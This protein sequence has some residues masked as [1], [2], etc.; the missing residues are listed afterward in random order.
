MNTANPILNIAQTGQLQST[1]I[2]RPKRSKHA[3]PAV[4]SPRYLIVH[5]VKCQ[6]V[7]T[8]TNHKTES[9]FFDTPRL[10]A[11]DSKASSLRGTKPAAAIT[12]DYLED[13]PEI[14]FIVYKSYNCNK[15]YEEVKDDFDRLPTPSVDPAVLSLF[16]AYFFILRADGKDAVPYSES[17]TITSQDLTRAI[18]EA[19]S[20]SHGNITGLD[21]LQQVVHPYEQFYHSR[22]VISQV[23]SAPLSQ[24]SSKSRQ[25]LHL[26]YKF[27]IDSC[28]ANWRA[29]D[30]LFQSGM[31]NE[32]H[33]PKLFG[34][35][36]VLVTMVDAHPMAYF[37]EES[38]TAGESGSLQFA[39]TS[40]TFDQVFKQRTLSITVQWPR[41]Q[42]CIPITA[43]K[44]YPLRYDTSGLEERLRKR[45]EQ[46]WACRQKAFV[47]YESPNPT[48]DLQT[49]SHRSTF[50]EASI[51]KTETRQKTPRYMVDDT[52][53]KQMH[54][55]DSVVAPPGNALG[56]LEMR[57]EQPPAGP[58]L[59]LLPAQIRGYG[60]HDKKWSEFVPRG[61][62]GIFT[63]PF[64]EPWVQNLTAVKVSAL[65][66]A[67]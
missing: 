34:S 51:N 1:D 67:P 20:L 16:K 14:S 10:F 32:I 17:F 19:K 50:R 22:A 63:L 57:A 56:Q 64:V 65:N 2:W 7:G 40:W 39:C 52:T 5:Q 25:Q 8:H 48:L 38:S 18:A 21:S 49:V 37:Q 31:V 33:F 29:A 42:D 28:G 61:E 62:R 11:G 43:L 45:G 36:Q 27:L 66:P 46:F 44:I 24:P 9:Y 60:M 30:A 4:S 47:G 54:P 6:Q 35:R 58:F 23:L 12:K 59:L 13:H 55:E 26:L 15:Y 53:Y 3:N 41:G